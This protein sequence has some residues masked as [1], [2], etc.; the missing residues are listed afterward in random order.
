MKKL[1]VTQSEFKKGNLMFSCNSKNKELAESE[2][3]KSV[4]YNSRKTFV[5][6]SLNRNVRYFYLVDATGNINYN[7]IISNREGSTKYQLRNF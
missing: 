2:I 6:Y 5:M 1:I 3:S 4:F 7:F